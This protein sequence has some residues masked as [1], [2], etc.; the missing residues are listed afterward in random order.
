MDYP[1]TRTIGIVDQNKTM[2]FY[3]TGEEFDDIAF[4]PSGVPESD[5]SGTGIKSVEM[6]DYSIMDASRKP[7]AC[8][9]GYQ[10]PPETTEYANE[11]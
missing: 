1:L 2:P 4:E 10:S 3:D 6:D 7:D 11:H 5:C 8:V 9:S